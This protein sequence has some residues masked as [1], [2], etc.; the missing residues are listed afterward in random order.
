MKCWAFSSP[1][2]STPSRRATN[3]PTYAWIILAGNFHFALFFGIRVTWTSFTVLAAACPPYWH[4]NIY[5]RLPNFAA[6]WLALLLCGPGFE[7]GY[8]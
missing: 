6:Q 1:E 8:P 2:L 7:A 4:S 5:I 3:R